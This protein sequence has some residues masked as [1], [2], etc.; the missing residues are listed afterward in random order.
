M[1]L[2]AGRT[3]T[4]QRLKSAGW[5]PD[6]LPMDARQEAENISGP[7]VALYC[8]IATLCLLFPEWEGEWLSMAGIAGIV[9]GASI[10]L[11]RRRGGGWSP[12]VFGISTGLLAIACQQLPASPFP[13]ELINQPAT[14]QGWIV[15]RQDRPDSV[16]LLLEEGVVTATLH[17]LPVPVAIPGL[18][19][20]TLRGE[21]ALT[22]LPG[23]QV[24][25]RTRLK[26]VESTDNPGAFDYA[27]FQRQQGIQAQGFSN[28]AVEWLASATGW[29]WNRY[30]QQLSQ[31]I[32]QTVSPS[33]RGLVEALMVGKTGFLGAQVTEDLMVS[34]TYHLVAISGLQVGLVAGWSFFIA[35]F[36][37]ALCIPLSRQWDVKRPAALLALP[38]TVAYAILAGWSISTQRATWMAG[39]LLVAIAV[40]RARQLWRVLAMAA[41]AILTCQPWQLF[42]AGFQLSFLSVVGLLYFMPLL[43]T[44]RGWWR[45]LLGLLAVTVVAS[46]V[47]T[48][49]AAHYFHRLSPYGLPANLLAVPWVSV[50]STPLGLLAMLGHALYPPLGDGLLQW[51][52]ESLE[53]YRLLIA[54]ISALP[55]AWSRVAG[56]SLLG[57]ALALGLSALA[58][59]AGMAG[60][61]RW[62]LPLFFLAWPALFWPHAAP[63][64]DELHLA[65]LDVG[66]AQSVVLY[67]PQGG[68]S[69]LDAGGF[70][71]PRFNPGEAFT[72]AYLWHRGVQRLNR[73]VVSH[74]QLDHMAGVEQLL[75][76]FQV[77]TLWL[78]VFPE[79]EADNS[80]YASLIARAERQGVAIR[81]IAQGFSVEE[82]DARITVLPPLPAERAKS[83]ND[84]SLVVE[85]AFGEQRYLIPGDATARTEKWL[86]SQRAIQPLTMVLAPHHG[87]KTSSSSAFVQTSRPQHVVFSAG[88]YNPHRHPY[89]QVVQRWHASGARLWRTDQQGAILLQS[90]GRNLQVKAATTPRV[91]LAERLKALF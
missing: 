42:S 18:I 45:P 41:L 25:L 10:L 89:F 68:W 76:N 29:H 65:V 83:D 26:P 38:P 77:E 62:R 79:A 72:S 70:V 22:A 1:S 57:L 16:Q 17:P 84:R 61:P 13:T 28:Q 8:Q 54:W 81:R 23:D 78:G 55:G 63:P 82:G 47:T 36:L 88:R 52:G 9:A 12:I 60:K 2:W 33:E 74:P 43:P 91:S 40:G 20:I 53:P 90:D 48:P 6:L 75:R 87:S 3:T 71:S 31:W 85:I 56:P 15:E 69:V 49:V 51:M 34:G 27:R 11:W 35:R 46:L 86:L 59:L 24:R 44:G 30:R 39:F 14:L 58:G 73:V 7:V 19:Q 5:S 66:Q 80:T 64:A 21:A 32:A 4:G 37:L 67:T 50:V